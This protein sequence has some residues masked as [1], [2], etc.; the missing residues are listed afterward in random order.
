MSDATDLTYMVCSYGFSFFEKMTLRRGA[1]AYFDA[2]S[3]GAFHV[4]P[5]VPSARAVTIGSSYLVVS[6]RAD[7]INILQDRSVEAIQ[8]FSD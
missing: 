4:G 1:S 6:G 2:C 8:R 7:R 5:S 3:V